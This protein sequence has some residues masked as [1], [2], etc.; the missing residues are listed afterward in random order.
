MRD[1]PVDDAWFIA[2]AALDG[3]HDVVMGMAGAVQVG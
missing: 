3:N 2:L 1:S